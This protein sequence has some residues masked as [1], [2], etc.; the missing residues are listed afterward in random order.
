M[1]STKDLRAVSFTR[2]STLMHSSR[3]SVDKEHVPSHVP[4]RDDD[5]EGCRW[6]LFLIVEVLL[7]TFGEIK[8]PNSCPS[9]DASSRRDCS[10]CTSFKSSLSHL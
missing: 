2:E 7:S 10:A 1:R 9:S 8:Y 3:R 4:S 5:D 6:S